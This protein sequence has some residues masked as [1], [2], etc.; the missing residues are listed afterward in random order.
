MSLV[1]HTVPPS[2]GSTP[3]QSAN[4]MRAWFASPRRRARGR[5]SRSGAWYVGSSVRSATSSSLQ[6]GAC[7]AERRPRAVRAPRRAARTSPQCPRSTRRPPPRRRRRRRRGRSARCFRAGGRAQREE[8]GALVLDAASRS[9]ASTSM[10]S[11]APWA[12]WFAPAS[13]KAWGGDGGGGAPPRRAR[14]GRFGRGRRRKER[15]SGAARA[16]ARRVPRGRARVVLRAAA[17]RGLRAQPATARLFAGG[18][19]PPPPL[20]PPP[21]S[22][23][24]PVPTS[25]ARAPIPL[26]A[27]AA[28]QLGRGRTV[29]AAR[30]TRGPC[31]STV[32][33]GESRGPA[34]H[35]LRGIGCS[36]RRPRRRRVYTRR[37]PC[38]RRSDG[39]RLLEAAASAPET[40]DL[41]P[42][43]MKRNVA[44]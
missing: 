10:P 24:R 4:G 29:R 44:R 26:A 41:P 33:A 32:G 22:A 37:A 19:A 42:A 13:A 1:A 38:R 25:S 8:R 14:R 5:G 2:T 27:A 11:A 31:H 9:S 15:V 21:E 16:R 39:A 30:P 36:A 20:L 35:L 3:T 18:V 34:P 12:W 17:A 23:S 6:R 43:R 28:L 7:A 40:V